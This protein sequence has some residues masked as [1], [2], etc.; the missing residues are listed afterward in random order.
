MR[1]L[2]YDVVAS[3][4]VWV[5]VCVRTIDDVVSLGAKTLGIVCVEAMA[6]SDV[7]NGGCD[8]TGVCFECS[9]DCCDWFAV[10]WRLAC[11]SGGMVDR[12]V[13]VL[14]GAPHKFAGG[15]R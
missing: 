12:S 15:K 5:C 4:E 10:V 8:D 7:E 9:S 3:M 2:E 1:A 14:D 11:Y 6:S 13:I